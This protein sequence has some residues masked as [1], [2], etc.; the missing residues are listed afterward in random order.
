MR[1]ANEKVIAEKA[2]LRDRPRLGY[3]PQ[4]HDSVWL[5]SRVIKSRV[6]RERPYTNLWWG[7]YLIDHVSPTGHTVNLCME[8]GTK[9]KAVNVQYICHYH[10]PLMA[11]YG[12]SANA[13]AA[14]PIAI[15]AHRGQANPHGPTKHQYLSC[16]HSDTEFQ[17]WLPAEL[18]PRILIYE[19]WRMFQ[20]NPH[21]S[22]YQPGKEV[23]SLGAS[24][25]RRWVTGTTMSI[26]D[27]AVQVRTAAGVV[28]ESYVDAEGIL[29]PAL[30]T[31]V[32]EGHK[33]DQAAR[34][35]QGIHQPQLSPDESAQIDPV[36]D[37]P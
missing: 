35:R 26:A 33:R 8:G 21:I 25:G 22:P 6:Q 23:V 36:P 32:E 34:T 3:A 30:D 31:T 20:K 17:E 1:S 18:L 19:W 11:T 9:I 12:A 14:R 37:S 15:L 7:P 13:L 5:Y 4:R 28:V 10:A 27:N 29:R 2:F 24:G 16:L